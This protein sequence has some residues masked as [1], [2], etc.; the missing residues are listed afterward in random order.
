M[1]KD[2]KEIIATIEDAN[3][4]DTTQIVVVTGSLCLAAHSP[5]RQIV[6]FSLAVIGLLM[7]VHLCI[8]LPRMSLLFS[9]PTFH[10]INVTVGMAVTR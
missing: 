8:V 2:L 9:V 7:D 3:G 5:Q 4:C 1:K 6:L 10:L